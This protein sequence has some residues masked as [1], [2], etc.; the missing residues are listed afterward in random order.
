LFLAWA[1]PSHTRRSVLLAR[2]LNIPLRRVYALQMRPYLAP[3]RYPVQAVQTLVTLFRERPRLVFVQNPPIFAPLFVWI[4][5]ALTGGRFIIDSHTDALHGP[6]WRW[7]W[8]LHRFLSR[9]A[10]TTLVTNTHLR[11]RVIGWGAHSLVVMDVPSEFPAGSVY[12]LQHAFNIAVASSFSADEPLAEVIAAAQ[13]L[14]DVG[15]Y[16]TGD[17]ARAD[18]PLPTTLPPNVHLTGFLSEEDYYGLMRSAQAVMVLTTVDHTMQRGACE[19]VWLGQPII[20]SHWP[21]L[22]EAFHRGTLHVD[23]TAAGIRAAVEAMRARRP[24]LAAEVS[25]LQAE[26][27]RHWE[28]VCAQLADLSG[29][30]LPQ[31]E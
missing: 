20:T 28:L 25:T 7:S 18:Y 16:V 24:E 19:A 15:F 29:S 1:R 23:N 13:S 30:P 17:P 8:P 10:V 27:R 6:L 4:Y 12:P 21:V 3:I 11:K 9:R 5:C 31:P 22:R 26:R 14:P 2:R